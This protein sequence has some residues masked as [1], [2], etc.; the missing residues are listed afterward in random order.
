MHQNRAFGDGVLHDRSESRVEEDGGEVDAAEEGPISD[1]R[2]FLG[3]GDGGKGGA[4][5]E[6]FLV[7]N[8]SRSMQR[9]KVVCKIRFLLS[10]LSKALRTFPFEELEVSPVVSSRS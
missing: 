7:N 6:G 1:R 4:A 9:R 5:A 2:E 10:R 3:E 8:G